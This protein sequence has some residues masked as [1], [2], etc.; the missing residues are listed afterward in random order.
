MPGAIGSGLSAIA[1]IFQYLNT[2]QSMKYL[3]DSVQCQKDIA[4]EEGKGELADDA[5]LEVLYAQ[6]VIY[7]QAAKDEIALAQASSK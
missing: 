3:N 6:A 5:K 7:F 2:A 4:D 1:A